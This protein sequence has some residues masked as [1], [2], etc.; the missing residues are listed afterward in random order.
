MQ[1]LETLNPKPQTLNPRREARVLVD[2]LQDGIQ[3]LG[4]QKFHTRVTEK[5]NKETKL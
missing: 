5:N 4:S 2:D 1:P 3:V